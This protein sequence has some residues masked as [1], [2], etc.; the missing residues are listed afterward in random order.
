MKLR[1]EL[2][3]ISHHH[4]GLFWYFERDGRLHYFC[5]SEQNKAKVKLHTVGYSEREGLMAYVKVFECLLHSLNLNNSY[6]FKRVETN[7]D[8]LTLLTLLSRHI[9]IRSGLISVW[10]ERLGTENICPIFGF[11][12]AQSSIYFARKQQLLSCQMEGGLPIHLGV[13]R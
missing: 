10:W 5:R 11:M 9:H 8:F 7:L 1:E 13:C 12:F 3:W 6:R 4:E 2:L